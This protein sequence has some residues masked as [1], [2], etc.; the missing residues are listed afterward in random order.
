MKS[1]ARA[2]AIV[3]SHSPPDRFSSK[4]GTNMARVLYF[5]TTSPTVDKS[6]TQHR[7]RHLGDK[8]QFLTTISPD[9]VEAVEAYVDAVI[10]IEQ[11]RQEQSTHME[12]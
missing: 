2:A 7:R 3:Y 6:G 10:K 8:L 9:A 5:A 4:G 11:H 1:V 12:T